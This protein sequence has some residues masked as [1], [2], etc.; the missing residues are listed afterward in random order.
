MFVESTIH[1]VDAEM[2]DLSVIIKQKILNEIEE[3]SK[4]YEISKIDSD[5]RTT[6]KQQEYLCRLSE[7]LEISILFNY[8]Y[9]KSNP[10][11]FVQQKFE[12]TPS[13][14]EDTWQI[15][16]QNENTV[17]NTLYAI[18]IELSQNPLC[19][20][21]QIQ[22]QIHE[23]T[24]EFPTSMAQILDSQEMSILNKISDEHHM[25]GNPLQN[26]FEIMEQKAKTNLS[27]YTKVQQIQSETEELKK[28]LNIIYN[29]FQQVQQ[30][31]RILNAQCNTFLNVY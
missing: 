2:E 14:N 23:S 9:P 13:I 18:I 6:L 15:N 19:P 29:K 11:Y 21:L 16:I 30:E 26:L 27:L 22:Q 7:N 12:K 5:L 28:D 24:Q 3:A 8:D 31:A 10:K 1:K 20:D 4:V 25:Y 17:L